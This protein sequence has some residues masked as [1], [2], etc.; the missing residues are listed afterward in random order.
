[1]YSAVWKEWK[2]SV[3]HVLEVGVASAGATALERSRS[4]PEVLYE[5]CCETGRSFEVRS[6]TEKK[7]TSHTCATLLQR[8]E[9]GTAIS[10]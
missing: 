9:L 3:L 7:I 10:K 1:M 2:N 4:C 5:I 6:S 8:G